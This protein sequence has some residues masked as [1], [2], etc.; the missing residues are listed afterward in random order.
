MAAAKK[1]IK[2]VA[3]KK[4]IAKT[5]PKKAVVKELPK[6]TGLKLSVY[7]MLGKST[8]TLS[9]PKEI[10]GVE[11]NKNL[12]AQYARVYL[13]NQRRGTL[14]TKSR[15]E[16]NIST[17]KIYRQKGTGRARHGAASAPIFV[18]GGI[19]FG[20][21][22]RDFSLK[23]NQKQ[24]KLALFSA[25]SSKLKDGEIKLI[26]GLEKIEPK[27]KKMSDVLKN[28]SLHSKKTQILL[29][30]PKSGKD[31]E[32]IVKASRNIKG[33]RISSSNLLNT[34]EVLQS[35]NIL[36]MKSAIEGLRENYFKN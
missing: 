19:A 21:K 18:G 28:L 5:A 30:I 2:K 23:L 17:R 11:V 14:K 33:V 1:T 12:L 6:E 25:L 24:K 16:V 35:R 27:T 7:N 9:L 26:T 13:A 20:P 15:G 29:I 36:F 22:Q 32:N 31:F 34:Y 4:P 10:F 3:V 8:E